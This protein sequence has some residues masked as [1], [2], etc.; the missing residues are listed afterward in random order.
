M[1][2]PG[3]GITNPAT[4]GPTGTNGGAKVGIGPVPRTFW[5]IVVAFKRICVYERKPKTN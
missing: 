4:T 3:V 2:T 5:I 1:R